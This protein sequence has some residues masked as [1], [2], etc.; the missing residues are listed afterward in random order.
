MKKTITLSLLV[1]SFLIGCSKEKMVDDM[2]PV[3]ATNI[4]KGNFAS[5]AHPTTGMASIKEDAAGRYLVFENFK[6][7]GG[8]NLDVYLSKDLA[9]GSFIN[10][11]DLKGT[12]GNFQYTVDKTIDLKEYKYVLIWCVDFKVLFGNAL[13]Q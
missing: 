11:G 1:A 13:L 5:N 3:V 12:S 8:P 7:D 9:A 4:S 6:T 2:L 10:L